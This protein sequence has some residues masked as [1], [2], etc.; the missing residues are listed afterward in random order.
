MIAGGPSTALYKKLVIDSEIASSLSCSIWP[1][2]GP[3][4]VEFSATLA[5]DDGVE[6]VLDAIR[7]Q[8]EEIAAG[9]VEQA[10]LDRAK[11][12]MLIFKVVI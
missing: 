10:A 1:V 9:N 12:C 4:M 3:S 11:N 6:L 5:Q 8:L 2:R 7:S